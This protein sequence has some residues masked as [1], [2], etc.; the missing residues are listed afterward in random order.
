M[1]NRFHV[2]SGQRGLDFIVND[3]AA[4]SYDL[5]YDSFLWRKATKV[6]KD[7]YDFEG[8]DFVDVTPISDAPQMENSP[9][10][11]V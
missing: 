1:R 3:Y 11:I 10:E 7:D 9:V 4:I 2:G 8:A 5:S 6:V